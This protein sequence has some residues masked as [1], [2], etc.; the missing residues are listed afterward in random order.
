MKQVSVVPVVSTG[1]WWMGSFDAS[2]DAAQGHFVN[3]DA[4]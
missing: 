3:I 2:F 4:G 1:A